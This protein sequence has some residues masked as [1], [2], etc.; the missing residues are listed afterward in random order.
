MV[1]F[2][3]SVAKEWESLVEAENFE[4][5]FKRGLQRATLVEQ[6][7][8]QLRI[9]HEAQ[10]AFDAELDA[11]ETPTL[12]IGTLAMHQANPAVTSPQDLIEGL[13]KT[14]SLCVL[15]GQAHIGKST[16]ALQML[17]CLC[18][19]TDF[20]GAPVQQIKSAGIISY[21]QAAAIYFNWMSQQPGL[22][23][24]AISVVDANKTGN[25]LKVPAFRAQIAKT[26]QDM[27][28]EVVVIDSFSAS[29]FGHDQNDAALTMQ[30]YR[31]LKKFALTEVGAKAL[32]VLSHS[33]PGNVK[34]ARG[35]T[36]H[37]DVADSI[38]AMY[39]NADEDRQ[40]DIVKYRNGLGQS[41]M[42]SVV[43]TAPDPVTHLVDLD[44]GGMQLAGLSLP[45]SVAGAAT[46]FPDEPD[47]N[48]E[49]DITIE[50]D[51]D[52]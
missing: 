7:V 12:E 10:I 47:L 17:Y 13:L 1:E 43:T 23:P 15:I 19:G 37:H 14:D 31:D 6:K 49:P 20:L 11:G 40:I 38:V 30:H 46:M 42:P 34:K 44:L 52:L 26:W 2:P 8:E 51:D 25:P 36:V 28:V 5:D 50:E 45:S 4:K 29:F 21:D 39:K 3:E 33:V 48:E 22:D 24:N 35:S 32:I 18:T 9:R 27:G 16:I 41:P